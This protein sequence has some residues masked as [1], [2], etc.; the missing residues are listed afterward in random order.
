[1]FRRKEKKSFIQSCFGF[2]WPQMGWTRTANYWALR[3]N[4][5]PG[6]V[7][8]IAGGFACGAAV[9]FT[10]FVGLHFIF[11][12]VLAWTIRGNIIA[13]AFG[14]AV[15]NPWTFPFI[16]FW[17]YKLGLWMGFGVQGPAQMNFDFAALFGQASEAALKFNYDYFIDTAWPI[18][19]PMLMGSIPTAI[20]MWL[21][22]YYLIKYIINSYRRPKSES[23][24]T[25]PL[26]NKTQ[27]DKSASIRSKDE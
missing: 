17:I 3:A 5:L 4:R 14:T 18:L 24:Q 16:W 2:L 21:F 19:W 27:M 15:G 12:G 10:P 13:A 26:T 1:M 8:S 22:S 6:S 9:S 23:I 20:V 7:Y 25:N 11:G